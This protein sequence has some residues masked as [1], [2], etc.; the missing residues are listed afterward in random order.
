MVDVMI[1][2]Q[3][4]S[5]PFKWIEG[6]NARRPLLPSEQRTTMTG[7]RRY[8]PAARASFGDPRPLLPWSN[9][10]GNDWRGIQPG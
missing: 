10:A 9:L 2:N 5:L 4:T 6:S 1:E 8:L 3:K 7:T